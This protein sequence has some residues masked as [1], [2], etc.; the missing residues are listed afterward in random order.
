MIPQIQKVNCHESTK[1]ETVTDVKY[2]N[3]IYYMDNKIKTVS[4]EQKTQIDF[5]KATSEMS[6]LNWNYGKN[7]I[8]NNNSC[9]Q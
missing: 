3:I 5:I 8:R 6:G 1:Q 4:Q 7:F 2:Q 9:I